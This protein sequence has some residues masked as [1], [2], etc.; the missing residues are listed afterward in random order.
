LKYN[1][2]LDGLRFIAVLLV[3]IEHFALNIG[4]YFSAGFYGV[5]LFFVLSGFLITGILLNSKEPFFL[6]Y[7]KFI[8]RRTLR[9]FPI[10]YLSILILFLL[11]NKYVYQYLYYYLTYTYNYAWG[12]FNIPINETSHFWSLCVE[13]QFYLF[14]P[15]LVLGLRNKISLL[16]YLIGVVIIF[17]SLQF[18]FNIVSFITLY[19]T[20]GLIP[21]AYALAIGAL[22]AIL[23]RSNSIPIKLMNSRLAE[24]L[25]FILL[26]ALL[27][28]KHKLKFT[29]CPFLSLFFIL[30]AMH[31]SFSINVFN[32][33]LE[34]KTVVYLGTISYGIYL[35]HQPLTLYVTDGFFNTFI[36]NKI[37]WGASG[38]LK[39]LQWNS[40][41]FKFPFYSLAA[42]ILAHFSYTYIEKPILSLKDKWFGYK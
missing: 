5:D 2:Q 38:I 11:G 12:Y 22:G 40:W 14:W 41:V 4:K 23:Y 1:K 6:S 25:A 29:V 32:K 19:N 3:L 15:F 34:N 24:L 18:H 36:W 20:V 7:K 26:A 10:Y 42:I 27:T 28:A 17:C 16:K 21:Q 8:G 31:Y 13:E 30:K 35:Y 39:K 37:N 33:F 9:I